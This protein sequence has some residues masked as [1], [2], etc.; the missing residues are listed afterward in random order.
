MAG[1]AAPWWEN[2]TDEEV[3]WGKAAGTKEPQKESRPKGRGGEL[4]VMTKSQGFQLGFAAQKRKCLDVPGGHM[5][6]PWDPGA[7]GTVKKAGL[8]YCLWYMDSQL[9]TGKTTG[10]WYDEHT[11]LCSHNWVKSDFNC[12]L[13]LWPWASYLTLWDSVFLIDNWDHNVT[14]FTK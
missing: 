5:H 13:V 6:C 10:C 12:V 3:G 14:Y 1:T 2:T 7:T 8:L 4:G 9:E 11:Q